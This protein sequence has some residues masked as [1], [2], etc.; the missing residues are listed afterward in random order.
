MAEFLKEFINSDYGPMVQGSTSMN[1]FPPLA[2][3]EQAI[4][5]DVE[6]DIEDVQTWILQTATLY[7]MYNGNKVFALNT[8]NNETFTG[9]ELVA[10]GG[11]LSVEYPEIP[12]IPSTMRKGLG[13]PSNIYVDGNW[14]D[15]GRGTY[16]EANAISDCPAPLALGGHIYIN[17]ANHV[18]SV[19][20]GNSSDSLNI[21]GGAEELTQNIT[22]DGAD[23]FFTVPLAHGTVV[24]TYSISAGDWVP[25]PLNLNAT[26]QGNI[27]SGSG[28]NYGSGFH[29]HAGYLYLI[30]NAQGA[31]SS[32]LNYYVIEVATGN[33]TSGTILT[34]AH[35]YGSTIVTTTEGTPRVILAVQTRSSCRW[36][37][38]D[39][40]GSV[41]WNTV[42]NTS[43][44]SVG[45][46]V[47]TSIR[48]SNISLEVEAGVFYTP[49]GSTYILVD[50]NSGGA[51]GT[52][53]STAHPTYLGGGTQTV[54]AGKGYAP[55]VVTI[56]PTVKTYVAGILLTD[57]PT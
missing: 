46:A 5:T 8:G 1:L 31:S 57:Q 45:A 22:W 16:N 25:T 51:A 40:T 38:I 15:Q 39:N 47:Q 43:P 7:Q 13:T 30:S 9:R 12:L 50:F 2:A 56:P 17:S 52:Q 49:I 54:A 53:S 37:E 28:D 20:A 41:T 55:A 48:T 6:W 33:V 14:S 36:T 42:A 27:T 19:G 26:V 34:S 29:Y 4:I 24:N 3:T 11:V 23:T 35:Y 21:F 32:S 18:R 44:S 10:N